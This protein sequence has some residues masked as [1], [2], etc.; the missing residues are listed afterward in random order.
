VIVDG[1][2]GQIMEAVSINKVNAPVSS[3]PEEWAVGFMKQRNGRRS[4]RQSL[5]LNPEELEKHNQALEVKWREIERNEPRDEYYLAED[6]DF[7]ITAFGTVAR[8]AK[9][10]VD[11]LRGEGYRVGIVRPITAHP[12]P[13]DAY[14]PVRE[15]AKG[16]LCAEMNWGQMIKDVKLA[17]AERIPVE[18]YGRSGGACPGIEEITSASRKMIAELGIEKVLEV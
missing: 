13:Y 3:N 14:L 17:V 15:R 7:V 4:V 1:V 16:I 5:Y 11:D 18:F 9:S 10:V 2:I 6:A 8:I 12:F